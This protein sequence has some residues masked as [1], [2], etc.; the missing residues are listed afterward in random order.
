MT[1]HPRTPRRALRSAGVLLAAFLL[2]ACGGSAQDS[3][4]EDPAVT[5]SPALQ[6]TP[7][8][9][10][11]ESPAEDPSPAPE[12]VSSDGPSEVILGIEVA[13]DSI[14]PNAIKTSLPAGGILTLRITADRSGEFHV[15]ARPESYMQFGPGETTKS[16]TLENPGMVEIEEHDTGF[17]IAII[18]VR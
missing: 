11:E 8:P 7:S 1:L 5:E 13:G 14:S 9:E 6:A 17:T 12:P 16:V 10:A 4:K 18:E 2:A 3:V 15:H